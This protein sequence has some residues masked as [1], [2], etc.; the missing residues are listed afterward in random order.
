[1][2]SITKKK[3]KKTSKI[4][5][6]YWGCRR[7]VR[8]NIFYPV[9]CRIFGHKHHIIKTKL[10]PSPWYDV[11]TRMLYGVMSLV[12]WFVENDMDD[13]FTVEEREKE[14]TAINEN[15]NYDDDMKKGMI[16]S[17]V[18]QDNSNRQIML[19]YCW[20]K[21]YKNRE[22][23]IYDMLSEWHKEAFKGVEDDDFLSAINNNSQESLKLSE[24]FRKMEKRLK[25]EET[26][27]LKKAIELRERMWS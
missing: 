2:N 11:D 14:I 25:E 26:E 17:I 1:M 12:E 13:M 9:W 24:E 23:N 20:W 5:K 16:D 18:C 19:I 27:M 8:D 4:L 6:L 15:K 3:H 7:F 10:P 21:N 22:K